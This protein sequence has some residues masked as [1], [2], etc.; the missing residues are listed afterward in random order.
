M[1]LTIS[2]PARSEKSDAKAQFFLTASRRRLLWLQQGVSLY[3]NL[4]SRFPLSVRL[5]I[6]FMISIA[7][8][9]SV[10]WVCSPLNDDVMCIHEWNIVLI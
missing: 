7:S 1:C 10:L 8:I 9:K 6:E 3:E 5:V 2:I 4:R